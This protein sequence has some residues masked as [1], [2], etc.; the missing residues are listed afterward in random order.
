M[1][2]V[3]PTPEER[4][5][6]ASPR[7]RGLRIEHLWLCVP[8]ALVVWSGFIHAIPLLDFWWHLK[9]GEVI[10]QRGSLMR[11]DEFSFTAAGT[12]SPP[13][14]WL[15][16]VIYYLTYR[17]G[18]PAQLVALNTALLAAAL[19]PV[20]SLCLIAAGG[21]VRPAVLA[22][23]LPAV[24]LAVF[25]NM[26]P[27]VFSF[28]LLAVFFWVLVGYKTRRWDG[29]W[30]LPVLMAVWVNLHGAFVLG[31]ALIGLVLA[32]ESVRRVLRGP[33]AD[34]LT[35][36]ELGKLALALAVTA[37]VTL[38]NPDS[39]QIF[40]FVRS[41]QESRAV[42][43]TVLEW[44]PP[45]MDTWEGVLIFYGPLAVVVL[46][47]LRIGR[48]L[49]LTQWVVFVATAAFGMRAARNGIWFA[50]LSAPLLAW[51]LASLGVRRTAVG[52]VDTA[53]R[54]ALNIAIASTLVVLTVLLSPWVRPHLRSNGTGLR[55]KAT[56]VGAMDYLAQHRLQGHIFHSQIYGDYLIWRLW[57]EQR[58][59][60]DGRVHLFNESIVRD[61]VE[62]FD[63]PNWS[64]RL[65]RY[66]IRL[67][68]LEKA[69]AN[70][71]RLIQRV[72]ASAAWRILYEDELT[73]LAQPKS[74]EYAGV[75]SRD[76]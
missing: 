27:Q 50:L 7:G 70:C 54:P 21:R 26:R 56:P 55:A 46:A 47:S 12:P 10:V 63:D 61:Y 8:I 37:A 33:S 1:S 57:P 18:G 49:D 36:R 75:G 31:L 40:G 16:Q 4:Q 17:T 76:G 67:L 66:Q 73:I 53:P 25:G 62:V 43:A 2:L 24:L 32:C 35:P 6:P 11:T 60:I 34:T 41:I 48:Q 65:D 15:A 30:T 13:H 28:P 44:Q 68:L 58:S 38:A 69:D 64:A 20:L 29:L 3:Q 74:D 39:Y 52:P 14:A 51:A 9:T 59:F 23:L 5:L 19:L 72:R 45:R 42:Q 22:A 71:E